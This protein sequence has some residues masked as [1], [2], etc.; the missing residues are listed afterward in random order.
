MTGFPV[1]S[2]TPEMVVALE[3][4]VMTGTLKVSWESGGVKQDMTYQSIEAMLKALDYARGRL[5]D[6]SASSRRPPSTLAVFE[7]D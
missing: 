7:R 4:A 3:A 2:I 5:D 1:T 6:A